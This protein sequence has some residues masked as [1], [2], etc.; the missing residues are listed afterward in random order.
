[1]K[2]LCWFLKEIRNVF[3]SVSCVDGR[4]Y[5]MVSLSQ[6]QTKSPVTI[7]MTSRSR[8]GLREG[9]E[10]ESI[11]CADW[12]TC[13]FGFTGSNGDVM[14]AYVVI[15]APPTWW[16]MILLSIVYNSVVACFFGSVFLSSSRYNCT[17][18]IKF[19]ICLRDTWWMS[20]FYLLLPWHLYPP[21]AF[22]LSPPPQQTQNLQRTFT[23]A[24]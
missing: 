10:V 22:F 21:A 6:K 3:Q 16:S 18:L 14:Q 13:G 4:S 19:I 7:M 15:L 23:C 9:K 20:T 8:L 12:L 24:G 17:C 5:D 1:M 2:L 11:N